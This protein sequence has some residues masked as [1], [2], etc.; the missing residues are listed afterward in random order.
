[1][2]AKNFI[3]EEKNKLREMSFKMKLE[4]IWDYYKLWIIGI[5]CGVAF[6]TS[7][8]TTVLNKPDEMILNAVFL[9][10]GLIDVDETSIISGYLEDSGIQAEEDQVFIDVSMHID[11]SGNDYMNMN[12]DQK[13]MAYIASQSVDIIMG[14]EDNFLFYAG[15]GALLDLKEALP[16]ELLLSLE[17]NLYYA[18]A[19]E[20]DSPHAYGIK[21]PDSTVLKEYETFGFTPVF[22]IPANS[23]NVG[24]AVKFLEYLLK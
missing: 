8:I 11:R 9:N 19:E 10:T 12:Y 7:I 13:M 22:S 15:N 4:Y 21:I 14:D 6:L 24:N 5:I 2:S 17:E 20:D 1:M 16:E 3:D 18:S 23:P